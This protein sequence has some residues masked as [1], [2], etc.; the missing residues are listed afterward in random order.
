MRYYELYEDVYFPNRWHLGDINVDDNWQFVEGKAVDKNLLPPNLSVEVSTHGT[1][2]DYTTN[3]AFSVPVISEKIK[4]QLGDIKGVQF[5]P[6]TIDTVSNYFL[7]AIT[8]K[9]NCL[10]EELSV[11]EKFTENDPI[12]PDLAGHYS[13][14]SKL[15]VDSS[16]VN[17]EN[18][19]RI[20]KAEHF[21]IVSEKV[22]NAIEDINASGVKFLEV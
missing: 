21:L 10:N 2:L 5:I 9:I 6:V 18:I 19:F 12:R 22:K 11:F 13:C 8:Q 7:M 17:G 15:V 3:G 4:N 1:C 20:D 16:K 14:I